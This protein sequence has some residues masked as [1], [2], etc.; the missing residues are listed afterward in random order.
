MGL[1]AWLFNNYEHTFS[2]SKVCIRKHIEDLVRY[3]EADTKDYVLM[4]LAIYKRDPQHKDFSESIIANL[5][6]FDVSTLD[7]ENSVSQMKNLLSD[8][9]NQVVNHRLKHFL[10]TL[11]LRYGADAVDDIGNETLRLICGVY[12]VS[13]DTISRLDAEYNTFWLQPFIRKAWDEIITFNQEHVADN[14]KQD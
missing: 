6:L 4:E 12:D 2:D 3:I 7:N 5:A 9:H 14:V 11:Y 10:T 1:K 13:T 8:H